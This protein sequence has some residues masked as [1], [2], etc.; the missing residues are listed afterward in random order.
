MRIIINEK[1]INRNRLIAQVTMISGLAVLAGGMYVSFQMPD[2]FYLSLVALLLGFILSQIGIYFSN[3]WARRPR[4]DEQ[5]DQSLKGLDDKYSIYHYKTPSSHL[6]VG[7]AGIWAIFPKHQRG[8]ITFE[9][10]RWKQRGGG[11]LMT[12]LKVFAQEGLGRPDLEMIGVIESL[13][14]YFAKILPDEDISQIS[15]ALVFTHPEV[16]IDIDNEQDLPAATIPVNKLKDLIRKSAKNK[17][18]SLSVVK[19]LQEALPQN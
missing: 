10:E 17:P 5:I 3:R 8:T 18:I 1:T 2:Q 16:V 9:K 7:P 13:E 6:L 4:P 14:K 11:M 19:I 12:Y 15:A